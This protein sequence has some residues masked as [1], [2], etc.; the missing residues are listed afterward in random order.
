MP[1][2]ELQPLSKLAKGIGTGARISVAEKLGLRVMIADAALEA[3]KNKGVSGGGLKVLIDRDPAF[4]RLRIVWAKDG[5]FEIKKTALSKVWH[6][7]TI[8]RQVGVPAIKLKAIE[9]QWEKTDNGIGIDIDLPPAHFGSR[10]Q[11][12]PVGR[13][14]TSTGPRPAPVT[15]PGR[16]R[17]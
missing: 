15:V 16:A 6:Y 1:F 12:Q 3:L 13:P 14:S 8:G 11:V 17:V 4:P 2:V 5:Q 10:T 7:I 9:V